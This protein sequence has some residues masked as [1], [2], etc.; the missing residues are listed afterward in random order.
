MLGV[1]VALATGQSGPRFG[2]AALSVT[3]ACLAS[4]GSPLAAS[5]AVTLVVPEKPQR[6]YRAV[7]HGRAGSCA[8]LERAGIG[9]P[10]YELADAPPASDTPVAVAFLGEVKA[11]V[12]NEIAEVTSGATGEPVTVRSCSSNEG[13]HLTA[14]RGKPLEGRRLWHAYWYLGYDVEPSCTDKEVAP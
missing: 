2:V 6:V 14:W 9:G 11:T 8:A 1:V 10:Y 3:P 5:T 13:V 7:V 4:P 12:S